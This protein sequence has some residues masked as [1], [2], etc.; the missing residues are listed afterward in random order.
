MK[1]GRSP[2]RFDLQ[3]LSLSESLKRHWREY[4]MEAAALGI[5]MVS[6]GAFT[7]LLEYPT[8]ILRQA[9]PNGDVRR[10]MIGLAMG[11]TATGLIYSP[12][13]KRSG[14]HM[15]PAITI[16]FLRLGKIP[17]WDALFYIVFQ[18]LGGLTGVVFVALALGKSFSQPPVDFVATV[19]G[20]AG[21]LAAFI[22]EFF[23]AFVMMAMI[24]Y[25]SNKAAICQ[26]TGLFAGLLIM[27]YVTFEA[28]YSGFGMNPARTFA[29]ALPSGIW[30]A[31]WIYFTAAPLGMLLAAQ[32]YL[33][34]KD[35]DSI[36]CCKLHH[37]SDRRCIFCGRPSVVT[38]HAPQCVP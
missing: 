30:K 27:C 11:A 28:P 32:G 1:N 3:T 14:A 19:P 6:A 23:I 2:A 33:L 15:N 26:Y 5:F 20:P 12:W 13:G 16:T 31:I 18:F 35:C 9:L 21:D 37:H 22:G 34:V 24:V 4:L 10:G 29:S 36:Q 7:T 8:S 25:V 38:A 17:L